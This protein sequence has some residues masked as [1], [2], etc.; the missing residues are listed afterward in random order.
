MEPD[1]DSVPGPE[2]IVESQGFQIVIPTFEGDMDEYG[3]IEEE[4]GRSN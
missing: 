3:P 1:S 2:D 4:D